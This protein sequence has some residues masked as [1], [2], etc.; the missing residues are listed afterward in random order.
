MYYPAPEKITDKILLAL[1]AGPAASYMYIPENRSTTFKFKKRK[2]SNMFFEEE[3]VLFPWDRKKSSQQV[4]STNNAT[5]R[6]W[7]IIAL[8]V[9]V[10]LALAP[11]IRRILLQ[12]PRK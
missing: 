12:T 1:P 5:L 7:V 11:T 3:E 9:L 4:I 8:C 10:G 2:V 6:R